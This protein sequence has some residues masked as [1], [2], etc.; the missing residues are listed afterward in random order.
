MN[1]HD[2]TLYTLLLG[3]VVVIPLEVV[4]IFLFWIPYHLI[5]KY[6]GRPDRGRIARA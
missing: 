6:R 2:D 1:S 4:V 3:A 5:R